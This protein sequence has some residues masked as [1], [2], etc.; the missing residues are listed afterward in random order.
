MSNIFYRFINKFVWSTWVYEKQNACIM[1][2]TKGRKKQDKLLHEHYSEW[3]YVRDTECVERRV[4]ARCGDEQTRII[5]QDFLWKN[6][7]EVSCDQN[8]LQKR[9]CTRCGEDQERPARHEYRTYSFTEEIHG[10]DSTGFPITDVNTT[11]YDKCKICGH[12]T[13]IETEIE[14]VSTGWKARKP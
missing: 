10:N 11:K 8:E 3:E 4:C 14:H 7:T 13:N 2:R 12:E 5:H 1:F 6:L 9:T